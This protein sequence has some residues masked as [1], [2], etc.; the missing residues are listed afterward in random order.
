MHDWE[1]LNF[2]AATS[3]TYG[4]PVA[5]RFPFPLKHA[6]GVSTIMAEPVIF[7]VMSLIAFTDGLRH[8]S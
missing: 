1:R 7:V 8:N 4:T 2:F 5:A 6:G 3:A